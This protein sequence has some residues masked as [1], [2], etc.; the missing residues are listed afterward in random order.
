MRLLLQILLP[1]L[2]LLGAALLGKYMVDNASKPQPAPPAATQPLVRVAPA[3]V[4]TLQLDVETQGTVEARTS[5]PL[6]PQ[7][8][9]R[10][11]AMADALRGGGFFGAGDVLF[12]IEATDYELAIVQQEAAIARA[13]L[14]LL[15]EKA[16]ADTALRAWKQ[17]EG[18]KPPDSPL[19]T[20]A[21]QVNEAEKALA[22]A[23]AALEQARLN[24]QRTE[25]KAPFKGRVRRVTLDVGQQVVAGQAV[26]EIYA[27]DLAE[28][29]LPIPDAEAAFLELPLHA[30][31]GVPSRGPEVVLEAEFAG[32]QH[33]WTGWIDRTEGEVDRRTR[34][35]TVVARV[36]DPYGNGESRDRPPLALGMFV[37]AR[38]SGRTFADV[39]AIP[40]QALRPDGFVWLVDGENRLRA[41]RVEVLRQQRDTVLL[42]GGIQAGDLVCVTPLDTA[43]DGML[44]RTADQPIAEPANGK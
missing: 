21:P 38:I 20:R 12:A 28:V 26:A 25:V 29:R 35:L 43:T 3:T 14:R 27:T 22:A 34:Q 7:V 18:D 16:E 1:V 30:G 24:L 13:E 9:G 4:R 42:R 19:V 11:V 31:G 40:R 44:V 15:Q 17:L 36:P 2:V 23:R 5:I 32:Q 37:H 6:A 41:R 8:G 10:V 39:C 33:R